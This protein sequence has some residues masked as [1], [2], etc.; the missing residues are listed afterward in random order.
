MLYAVNGDT[1]TA[2]VDSNHNGGLDSGDR[3]VFTLQVGSNGNYTFTLLDKIDHLP[4][5]PAN[6]DAQ[7]L[8]VNLSSAI[9]V[10]DFD[11]NSITLSGGFSI[12]VEDDIPVLSAA[13]R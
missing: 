5:S 6:D 13:E 12:S 8:I 7:T 11:G 3:N 2:Y 4:N 1:L 10:T 9:K